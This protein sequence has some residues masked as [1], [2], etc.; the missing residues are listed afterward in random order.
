L[1]VKDVLAKSIGSANPQNVVKAT[2]NAL[3][4]MKSA[5]QLAALRGKTIEQII[6]KKTTKEHNVAA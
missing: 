1:G 6:G 4:K 3:L 2:I 5:K